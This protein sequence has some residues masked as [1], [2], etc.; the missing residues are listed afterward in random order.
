MDNATRE[1][2]L[3]LLRNLRD[4]VDEQFHINEMAWRTYSALIQMFPEFAQHYEKADEHVSFEQMLHW[5]SEQLRQLDAAIQ[6]VE[7]WK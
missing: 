7:S 4:T 3:N 1:A 5:R 6:L 2:L